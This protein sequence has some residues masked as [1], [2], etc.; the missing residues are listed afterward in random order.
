MKS[1]ISLL[2]N[3]KNQ[4]YKVCHMVGFDKITLM[5]NEWMKEL[6]FG[7]DDWTLQAH[8]GSYKTTVVS[9]AIALFMII[10]P[11][12][13]LMFIRKTLAQASEIA[14]QVAKI[15]KTDIFKYF[16]RVIY[17]VELKIVKEN[18]TEITTNLFQTKKG[19]A[20][21]LC[22]GIDGSITGKHSDWVHTDDIITLKDRV[23]NAERKKTDNF[24]QELINVVN[25]GGKITNSGTPW[26]K[27]DTF[28]LMPKA[29]IFDC[30]STGLISDE[31]LRKIKNQISPSLFAANYELKHIADENALFTSPPKIIDDIELFKNGVSHIDAAYGGEDYSAFTTLKRVGDNIYLF[32]KMKHTHIDNCLNEFLTYHNH[33][34]CGSVFCEL[35]A[36]KGYLAK[37]I[38]KLGIPTKTYQEKM[39]KFIKIS[40]YLKMNWDNIYFYKDTDPEY[41]SMIMDYTE[42]SKHDDSPDSAAS[43][44]RETLQIIRKGF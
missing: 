22:C 18:S 36:D 24:F 25:R 33:L 28:R 8:R 10:Y 20:Q 21:F 14:Y 13:N 2:N 30:Y 15:L 16:V 3:L 29:I 9:V 1:K 34:M 32:G 40:T 17:N 38:N 37:E 4:P 5:H 6:L 7:K 26:H 11:K 31:E 44:I 41:L 43:I 23:S 39:N 27:D 12:R 19:T 42:D 35:N